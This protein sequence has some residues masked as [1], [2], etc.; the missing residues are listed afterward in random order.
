MLIYS[1]DFNLMPKLVE[2]IKITLWLD[3]TSEKFKSFNRLFRWTYNIYKDAFAKKHRTTWER[4]FEHLRAVVNK[5]LEL[6]N[7]SIQ[8]VFIALSHDTIEDTILTYEWIKLSLWVRDLESWA[9]IALWV[10]AISKEPWENFLN[11]INTTETEAK[12]ARNEKYFWHMRSF[13]SMIRYINTLAVLS[14]VTISSK[15][16]DKLTQDTLDTKFADRI[17]NLSTQWDP[18]DIEKVERKMKETNDYF[19]DIAKETN[20]EAYK[21]LRFELWKLKISLERNK[22]KQE[23]NNTL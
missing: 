6:P 11:W 5:V 21:Q 15:E 3:E 16:L 4:Y 12:K 23:V 19:L 7:P 8:K 9:K 1:T 13:D 14:W 17:H 22:K 10:K 2:N 20:P 18:D